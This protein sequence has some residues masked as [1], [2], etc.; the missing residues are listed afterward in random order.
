MK[1]PGWRGQDAPEHFLRTKE[2]ISVLPTT[3]EGWCIEYRYRT[4]VSK[5][6]GGGVVLV[7]E[8]PR[9]T[10]G[11]P[12]KY[13]ERKLKCLTYREESNRFIPVDDKILSIVKIEF[14]TFI[15]EFNNN[16]NNIQLI[17]IL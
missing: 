8:K 5:L 12:A 3:V 2:D 13:L 11:T 14:I 6:S 10:V 7:D 15:K 17:I 1:K 9:W 16:I 4:S